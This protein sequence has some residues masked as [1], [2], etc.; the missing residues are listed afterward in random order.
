MDLNKVEQAVEVLKDLGTATMYVDGKVCNNHIKTLTDLAQSVLSCRSVLGEKYEGN[1]DVHCK[2]AED[3][4]VILDMTEK[5]YF[6]LG[7]NQR[8][9]EDAVIVAGK[10][11]GLKDVIA[12]ELL[13]YADAEWRKDKFKFDDRV[14]KIL[15][16]NIERVITDHITG[17][18]E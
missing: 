14:M 17:G 18:K 4:N 16:E 2:V 3:N 9:D 7:Y 11:V 12:Q 1:K 10:L 5:T 15:S 6:L 13:P 8:A